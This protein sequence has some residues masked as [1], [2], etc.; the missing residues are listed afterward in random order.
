M[1]RTR[2]VSLMTLVVLGLSLAAMAD[3]PAEMDGLPLVLSDDFE[4]GQAR[5]EMTDPKAWEVAELDPEYAKADAAAGKV[6]SLK[7]SSDYQPPVRSPH[8]IAWLKDL[9]VGDFVLEVDCRQTGREYG[10]RDLCFFFGRQDPA[11]FYY[12]HLATKADAHAN[13]IF[14][15]NGEPRVSIAKTRTDGTDWGSAYHK[16]RIKRRTKTGAIEVFF[17]DME[18]PVMTAEDNTFLSGTVG[19]G[20]FDDEG[21][22]DNLKV[23]A[24]KA[25]EAASES[26][27]SGSDSK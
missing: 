8:S 9:D 1:F 7:D 2:L 6:L 13:S 5:W 27:D 14:L 25:G 22:F 10:H 12:V 15:V 4:Q 18:K 21:R 3:V 19:L 20:T 16:V 26:K 17:D 11:H 24:K 23:W